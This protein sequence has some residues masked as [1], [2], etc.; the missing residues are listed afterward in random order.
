MFILLE[1]GAGAFMGVL[2]R[3]QWGFQPRLGLIRDLSLKSDELN[4]TTEM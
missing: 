3:S 1:I 2:C 4:S